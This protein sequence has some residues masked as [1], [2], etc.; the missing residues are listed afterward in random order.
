MVKRANKT[1]FICTHLLD[2]AKELCDV[3]G[4]INKGILLI[5]GSPKEV[6]K[7][8]NANNLEDAYIKILNP[9]KDGTVE[10]DY[11]SWR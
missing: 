6:I 1:V 5:E 3:I 11:L 9:S 10:K 4:L 8:V 7:S 2:V